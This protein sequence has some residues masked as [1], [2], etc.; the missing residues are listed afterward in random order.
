MENEIIKFILITLSV[1]WI[2]NFITWASY[3]IQ[4][5]KEKL[6]IDDYELFN[7]SKCL[8]FWIGIITGIIFFNPYYPLIISLTAYYLDKKL[9]S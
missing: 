9:N 8:G 4:L 2:V 3:P 5:L 7:C 6:K 1:S